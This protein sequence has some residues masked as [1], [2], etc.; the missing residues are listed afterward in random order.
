MPTPEQ[1]TAYGDLGPQGSSLAHPRTGFSGHVRFRNADE[2]FGLG[3]CQT[4]SRGSSYPCPE[5]TMT[6]TAPTFSMANVRTK[7]S[8]LG[9]TMST[10]RTPSP[11]PMST[12]AWAI[13][14]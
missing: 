13:A 6:G 10:V 8:R 11:I 7:N 1:A 14:V 3:V 5:S 4:A 12:R 2:R 9:L